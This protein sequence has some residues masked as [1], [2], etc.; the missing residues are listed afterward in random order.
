MRELRETIIRLAQVPP[1][2]IVLRGGIPPR[3]L[4]RL[5]EATGGLPEAVEIALR[6]DPHSDV[7]LLSG[8]VQGRTYLHCEYCRIQFSRPLGSEIF[9][10]VNPEPGKTAPRDP[11]SQGGVGVPNLPDDQIEA[12]GGELDLVGSL[13]DEWLLGLPQSPICSETCK[14]L[15]PVCG[16]NRNEAECSCSQGRRENP[17]AV[18]ARLKEG[19]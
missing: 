6:L 5:K 14:G 9:L 4:H 11:V 13:E 15:C 1:E 2:G 8:W 16:T 19:H 7:Y 3:R 10:T 17:F 12:P 18:L